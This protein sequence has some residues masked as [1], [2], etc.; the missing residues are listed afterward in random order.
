MSIEL[1]KE[2]EINPDEPSVESYDEDGQLVVKELAKE[3]LSKGAWQTIF[4]KYQEIDPKTGDFGEPKA[5]IR[6][7][8]KRDGSLRQRSKFNIS[9]AAQAQKMA[10]ILKRWFP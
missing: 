4:F 10:D 2:P 9:S 1:D 5:T 6:R 8:Q 3:Y 7:Y